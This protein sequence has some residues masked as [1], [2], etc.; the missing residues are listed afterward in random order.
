M[1][2]KNIDDLKQKCDAN[3]TV[4]KEFIQSN[5]NDVAIHSLTAIDDTLNETWELFKQLSIDIELLTNE[6]TRKG[7][8]L[9]DLASLDN[10][11]NQNLQLTTN[12]TEEIKTLTN[13]LTGLNERIKLLQLKNK[14]LEKDNKKYRSLNPDKLLSNIERVKANNLK[15]REKNKKALQLLRD[16][17]DLLNKDLTVQKRLLDDYNGRTLISGI[18]GKNKNN[19]YSLTYYH[20]SKIYRNAD[21]R[22]GI[23]LVRELPWSLQISC[24]TGI[25]IDV[26]FTVFGSPVYPICQ[27]FTHDFP[28]EMSDL[29]H[30]EYLA[31]LEKSPHANLKINLEMI[32]QF[33][34]LTATTLSCINSNEKSSLQKA[35]LVMI[36]DSIALNKQNFIH[37]TMAFEL[38]DENQASDLYDKLVAQAVNFKK[39]FIQKLSEIA[40]EREAV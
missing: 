35:K 2:S 19:A 29:V 8:L 16:N 10:E 28:E 3:L 38:I 7:L 12:L 33:K 36:Y 23:S 39:V 31:L 5:Q 4:T 40:K 18:K 15:E 20:S 21:L 24:S 1:L 25:S 26:A 14:E 22:D 32:K 27:D 9:I 13:Q 11:Y 30:I 34:Q 6:N 37:K 17:N